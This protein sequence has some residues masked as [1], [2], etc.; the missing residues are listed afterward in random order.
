MGTLLGI[1]YKCEKYGS[2]ITV[3]SA[4]VGLTTGVAQ[5][6]RGAAGKRQVTVLSKSSFDAAC[7][8]VGKELDWTTRRAN[9]LVDGIELEDKT[10]NYICIGDLV[11]EITGETA[12]CYRMDEQCDGLKEALKPAWRGGVTCRVIREGI[13]QLGDFVTVAE[14]TPIIR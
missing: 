8:E 12:P 2:V 13:I 10:G 11:L 9:L 1:G 5:D 6:I 3:K 14:S 7:A 4:K